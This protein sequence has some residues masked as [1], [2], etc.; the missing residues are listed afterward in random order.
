LTGKYDDNTDE[1]ILLEY[2]TNSKAYRCFN[3]RLYNLF[4]CMDLK[5]DEGVLVREV[6]NNESNTEDTDEAEDE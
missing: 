1:G 2:S 6:I 4:D 3:K 5:V